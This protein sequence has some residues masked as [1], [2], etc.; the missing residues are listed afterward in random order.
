M[1]ETV[2]AEFDRLLL[3]KAMRP[4][5]DELLAW[6]K[7]SGFFESPASR[8]FHGNF[9]GGLAAHSLGVLRVLLSLVPGRLEDVPAESLI[10][11]ALLHD[12]C[13]ADL[14]LRGDDGTYDLTTD[15]PLGHARLSLDLIEYFVE[16]TAQ[17]KAMIRFHMGFYRT[18]DFAGQDHGEY[19]LAEMAL[20]M[21]DP[22]VKLMYFA[23]EQATLS[24]VTR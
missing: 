6:L 21:D 18:T 5:M 23:D 1:D 9:P 19:T 14:Y 7:E 17:E 15:H 20:A 22:A 10:L 24:E 3:G 4:G 2:C 12:V 13:K 11:A 16:L 8:R